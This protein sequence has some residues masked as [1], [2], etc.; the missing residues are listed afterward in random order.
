MT[1]TSKCPAWKILPDRYASAFWSD[2][3]TK[4]VPPQSPAA[5][6]LPSEPHKPSGLKWRQ[7]RPKLHR[8]W[9]FLKGSYFSSWH[10]PSL[11]EIERAMRSFGI[12]IVVAV[13][14]AI[15]FAIALN[16]NQKTAQEE[17]STE[18]VRL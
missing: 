12:A 16:S 4:Q 14:L 11:S 10:T 5:R 7:F 3:R 15:G 8:T 2:V 9:I 17:F 1:P 18:A 6:R 13:V